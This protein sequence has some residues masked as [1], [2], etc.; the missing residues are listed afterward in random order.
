MSE[1]QQEAGTTPPASEQQASATT[2]P[3]TA[4]RKID[5]RFFFTVVVPSVSVLVAYLTPSPFK[6]WG[7]VC[8][9]ASIG[10][11]VVFR[12]TEEFLGTPRAVATVPYSTATLLAVT[13]FA[14]W[15]QGIYQHIGL[16]VY[17][18]II[19]LAL[20]YWLIKV[21]VDMFLHR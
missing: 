12:T 1:Q 5:Y 10:E 8:L 14:V 2:A 3:A 19:G 13:P 18:V 21:V 16:I 7:L 6:E 17:G 4:S 20:F 11:I 9:F 15:G